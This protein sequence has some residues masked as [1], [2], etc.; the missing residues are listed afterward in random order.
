MQIRSLDIERSA[1]NLRNE[2]N[3]ESYGIKDIFS[4]VD[5]M[6]IYLIRIPLGKDTI[7]GFSTIYEGKKVIVSNSSEILSREIFTIAHEIAHCIFDLNV[8]EQ[9][10]IIDKNTNDNNQD[11]IE[12]RADYFAAVLLMP[13]EKIREFIKY[14]LKKEF[15]EIKARDII[16]I[17]I[18]F[19]VSYA[20][21]VIRL[22]ELGF[23]NST[24]KKELFDKRDSN[25]SNMLFNV[26]NLNNDLIK[27]AD[28]L[29]VPNSYYEYVFS[30]YEKGYIVFDKLKE[31]LELV[32]FN[33]N[34]ITE[35][36]TSDDKD[37]DFDELLEGF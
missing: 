1:H 21:V 5:K 3:I 9:R 32:G 27:P 31:A 29:K 17:Q 11:Y 12:K 34:E 23:I 4:L 8:D 37:I 26:M 14:E 20:S 35:H 2:Y 22:F 16:R 30:N 6:D 18:E 15:G 28:I 7:C 10:L 13:E 33:T 19:N 24:T 25:T 36:T